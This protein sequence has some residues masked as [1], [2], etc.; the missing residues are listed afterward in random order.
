MLKLR[1]KMGDTSF[2]SRVYLGFA[3]YVLFVVMT[4]AYSVFSNLKDIENDSALKVSNIAE[5]IH[6][7]IETQ[8][9]VIDLT[10]DMM[11]K[12]LQQNPIEKNKSH[13]VVG[14]MDVAA[15]KEEYLNRLKVFDKDGNSIFSNSVDGIKINSIGKEY[16]YYYKNGGKEKLH[17]SKPYMGRLVKEPVITF[18]KRYNKADGQFAGVIS[19]TVR[20]ESMR[21]LLLS[22]DYG[23]QGFSL[24]RYQDDLSFLTKTEVQPNDPQSTLG[25]TYVSKQLREI[26][27]SGVDAK[28]F[29]LTPAPDGKNRINAYQRIEGT[30]FFL[31]VSTSAAEYLKHWNES[32]VMLVGAC[33]VLVIAGWL[34]MQWLIRDVHV[35]ED[36]GQRLRGLFEM[37]SAGIA[38]TSM[39]GNFVQF[40]QAF[41]NIC[42]YPE[43][44]LKSL[45][46]WALTPERFKADEEQQLQSMS[47]TGRYGPY[48]KQYR[49][50]DGNLVD[51]EL[52]G[53]VIQ[54]E[55]EEPY[56][57]SIV[58]DITQLLQDQQQLIHAKQ[59]AEANA[60]AK[61]QF[62]A[63]MS[64][65]LRTPL[66]GILGM[67]QLLARPNVND[68]HRIEFANTIVKS[69]NSL[70]ILLADLLDASQMDANK[71]QLRTEASDVGELVHD[72]ANLFHQTAVKKG[73]VL[74]SKVQL[75]Q[76]QI[77]RVDAVR[78]RQ[79]LSNLISN[80]IKFTMIGSIQIEAR[81]IERIDKEVILEFSVQDSG[82]GI[83]FDKQDLI[84]KRFSQIAN[85]A[86]HFSKGAGLGLSIV[87]G[88]AK[89]MGGDAGF[90]SE[91]GKGS[92]F[93]FRIQV[94]VLDDAALRS[95]DAKELPPQ[96]G[97]NT[98]ETLA[99]DAAIES[100]HGDFVKK[101]GCALIV[102]DNLINQKV[103][104]RFLSE[105]GTTSHCVVNGAE[106]IEVIKNGM[107]PKFVLMDVQMPVMN[108]LEA[109]QKIRDW[110]K[111]N[112]VSPMV[113]IGLTAGSSENDEIKCRE[114]GMDE[115]LFKPVDLD[116][117]EVIIED[118]NQ[119]ELIN[120]L[121]DAYN[122]HNEYKRRLVKSIEKFET[123]DDK[124]IS[125]DDCCL[126]GKWLYG[127]G[128]SSFG[129]FLEF[130]ELK[131]RHAIFHEQA[132]LIAAVANEKHF[133]TA[134]LMMEEGSN[135]AVAT[136]SVCSA[137]EDLK[138]KIKA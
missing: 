59:K 42:G 94:I 69:G 126:L 132:G 113:I 53:V 82:V 5:S 73:L 92:R 7:T 78:L 18:S 1:L 116:E 67:A 50:K 68:K 3:I 27:A 99:S 40:N 21:K 28:S 130:D 104:T 65:E 54:K 96:Q 62:L 22:I 105:I 37:S 76:A 61:S 66:N 29:H 124:S 70:A 74:E 98:Q 64:H 137:I 136:S 90:T 118:I 133:E 48:R 12:S 127:N 101:T 79:M 131:E 14:I 16:F 63:T 89:R 30:P 77:Y 134:L 6:R 86:A 31:I 47:K 112:E 115:V 57:W 20:V 128:N 83:P 60:I 110:E 100:V 56:V 120:N 108:G 121:E 103:I 125:R 85:D 13:S 43:D 95:S 80:A 51:V 17:I 55:G 8:I 26:N 41:A 19:A 107:K 46:Y 2:Q 111:A 72:V 122:A 81:E 138:K 52:I 11:A 44:E 129:H 87:H 109:T 23:L 36:Q 88:L 102:E 117:L 35:I 45:D 119:T 93:W 24:L 114:S 84:F 58:T 39:S 135:Y 33:L 123:L 15:N 32:I 71:L 75:P 10:L 25:N 4:S 49:R 91:E 106:A 9:D 34:V 97:M 38:Q